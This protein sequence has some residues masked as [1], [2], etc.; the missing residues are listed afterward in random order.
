MLFQHATP[1]QPYRQYGQQQ[2]EKRSQPFYEQVQQQGQPLYGQQSQQLYG[3]QVEPVKVYSK[4][5]ANLAKI[6]TEE[7]KCNGTDESLD[8][9]LTIFYDIT[10][11]DLRSRLA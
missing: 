6:Y 2:Y 7:Q 1:Q 4:K 5:V 3:Q 9:K 8:Y 11:S 10:G